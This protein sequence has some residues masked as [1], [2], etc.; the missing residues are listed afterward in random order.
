MFNGVLDWEEIIKTAILM[1]LIAIPI[2]AFIKSFISGYH[3][4][5]IK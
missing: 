4:K 1:V 5:N 2:S 3:G